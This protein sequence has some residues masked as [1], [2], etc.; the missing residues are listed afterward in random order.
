MAL[1]PSG[2]L[3]LAAGT[4]WI[5]VILLSSTSAAAEH[6]GRIFDWSYRTLFGPYSP[7]DRSRTC[8][9]LAEKSVHLTLFFVLGLLL[10]R[11]PM[12]PQR[13]FSGAAL[14]AGLIVGS[15]SEFLQNFFP[16]RDPALR[17][18]VINVT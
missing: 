16:G 6:A 14:A 13:R 4:A 15:S 18:V 2:R 12:A 8:L 7:S 11:W 3:W 9:F 5:V 10:S 17:D 1:T